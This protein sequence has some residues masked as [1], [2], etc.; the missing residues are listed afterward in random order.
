MHK[1]HLHNEKTRWV[2]GG[3]AGSGSGRLCCREC[4]VRALRFRGSV[5]RNA[6]QLHQ[7]LSAQ[8]CM[9]CDCSPTQST[10]RPGRLELM[11]RPD[12]SARAL[13]PLNISKELELL[14][15]QWS[16]CSSA[17]CLT[18]VPASPLRVQ[19]RA[20]TLSMLSTNPRL[21]TA[22]EQVNPQPH[23]PPSLP[24]APS[25]FFSS[26]PYCCLLRRVIG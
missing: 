2:N 19:I 25:L 22:E 18:A 15:A 17:N 1:S 12:I 16:S 4:R 5:S 7:R 6:R 20:H 11:L 13:V 3:K 10:G 8:A 26:S 23:I 24:E 9:M 14:F 21:Q